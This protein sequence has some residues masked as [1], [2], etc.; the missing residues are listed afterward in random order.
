MLERFEMLT[1]GT[2]Q[3]YKDIQK[4]KKA[5]MN[6]L[7][8]KGTHA[9]CIYYLHQ[10]PE[11][12]TATELC[13]LCR[14]DKAGISRIL[15]DLE[16]HHFIEYDQSGTG[17]K[18]RTK[19]VLTEEGNE[20]ASKVTDLILHATLMGGKGLSDEDRE[21]FYRVLFQ[22]ANNLDKLCEEL[23]QQQK[24]YDFE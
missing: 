16:R 8:L 20:Y 10:N 3:I 21:V 15:A 7:G 24:G 19:A 5:R 9:M 12:L 2:S 22:I 11:G 4:I 13:S 1:L 17:K 23:E 6:S 18:Y 14:E